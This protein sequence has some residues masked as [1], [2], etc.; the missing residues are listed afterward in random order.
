MTD[1]REVTFYGGPLHGRVYIM[2]AD[3]DYVVVETNADGTPPTRLTPGT[4]K[5]LCPIR[6]GGDR[7]LALWDDSAELLENEAEFI[8]NWRPDMS[9]S[10]RQ[11]LSVHAPDFIQATTVEDIYNRVL[12]ELG[13]QGILVI[14]DS[15]YERSYTLRVTPLPP[16]GC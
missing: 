3:H 9:I 5:H 12:R 7:W 15:G 8:P 16:Q 2:P 14:E 6:W 13:L 1:P 10:C 4:N 11:A